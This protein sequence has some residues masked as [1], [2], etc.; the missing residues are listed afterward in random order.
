MDWFTWVCTDHASCCSFSV[1]LLTVVP[2]CR[3]NCASVCE[4]LQSGWYRSICLS[5]LNKVILSHI[6]GT[7]FLFLAYPG[8]SDLVGF[9]GNHDG[10]TLHFLLSLQTSVFKGIVTWAECIIDQSADSSLANVT[11][12]WSFSYCIFTLWYGIMNAVSDCCHAFTSCL[13]WVLPNNA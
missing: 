10:T 5:S 13:Y 9:Y 12:L 4:V 8:A 2:L 3:H 6:V 1:R 7:F 11:S